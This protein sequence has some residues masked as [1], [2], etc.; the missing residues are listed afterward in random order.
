M[1]SSGRSQMEAQVAPVSLSG[2]MGLSG[3]WGSWRCAASYSTLDRSGC[4]SFAQV[5]SDLHDY[6][7]HI[8]VFEDGVAARCKKHPRS[9]LRYPTSQA[10]ELRPEPGA[11]SWETTIRSS[12]ALG[13]GSLGSFLAKEASEG[14]QSQRLI[15]R[16]RRWPHG[17]GS[18]GRDDEFER[19]G[20][21]G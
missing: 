4:R 8:L 5:E 11:G 2:G 3:R 20:T 19:Q 9:R 1:L 21:G 10:L 13:P 18:S 14:R 12:R 7:F 15:E 17:R 6:F 16:R